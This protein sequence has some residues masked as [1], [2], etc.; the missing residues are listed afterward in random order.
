MTTLGILLFALTLGQTSDAVGKVETTFDTTVNFA[1]LK[2][3]SWMTG[4][5]AERAS[6]HKMIVESVDAEMAKSG[7]TKVPI[8]ADV[9]LA[10]YTVRSTYVDVK[11]LDKRQ[12]AGPGEA[13][14]TN[15][16]G[17]LVLIMRAGDPAKQIWSASTREF[18]DPDPARLA[19][20]IDTA[21]A[22]LFETYPTRVAAR[23]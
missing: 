5:I 15:A 2:T 9:T 1:T 10:Y 6:T 22:R 23:R 17:R 14:P 19:E 20:T 4:Y 8:G 11:A 7:F 18:M 12:Q 3:Y 13:A 21:T 16:V